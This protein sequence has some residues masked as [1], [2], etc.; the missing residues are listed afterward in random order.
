MT[1][2]SLY[3]SLFNSEIVSLS[4]VASAPE[5]LNVEEVKS[6]SIFISWDEP[7]YRNGS[8][9]GYFVS[10]RFVYIYKLSMSGVCG[11]VCV[12]G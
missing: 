2:I 12:W 4:S 9:I 8:I 1:A 7:R 6:K 10:A 3:N 11:G 5:L